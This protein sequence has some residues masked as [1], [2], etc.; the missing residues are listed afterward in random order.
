MRK[1]LAVLLLAGGLN[2]ALAAEAAERA[3]VDELVSAVNIARSVNDPQVFE[4][5]IAKD[6]DPDERAAILAFERVVS[7]EARRP[8]SEVSIPRL[9]VRAVRFIAPEVAVVDAVNIQIGPMVR[10]VFVVLILRK[11]GANWR[12]AMLR[13]QGDLNGVI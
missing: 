12:I 8:M 3:A 10:K 11:E 5:L 2:A 13:T 4:A 7:A 1:I 9:A 6:A